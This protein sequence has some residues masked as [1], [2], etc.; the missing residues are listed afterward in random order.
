MYKK[1]LSNYS[2]KSPSVCLFELRENVTCLLT[3]FSDRA[4]GEADRGSAEQR[5]R[6]D[7]SGELRARQR[8][9]RSPQASLKAG[10][11]IPSGLQTLGHHERMQ[12][13]KWNLLHIFRV[14]ILCLNYRK[15]NS[16]A[17]IIIRKRHSYCK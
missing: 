2:Y 15:A 12:G 13:N 1:I 7:P 9:G 16:K 3:D 4:C 6:L 5:Q 14:Q 8:Q 11:R 10:R 17:F